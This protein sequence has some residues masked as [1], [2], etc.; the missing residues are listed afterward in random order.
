MIILYCIIS[1]LVTLSATFIAPHIVEHYRRYKT[2][3]QQHLQALVAT[4]V[5]KQ[6]KDIIND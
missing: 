2:R 3:K 4:E 6:L 5:A 1:A